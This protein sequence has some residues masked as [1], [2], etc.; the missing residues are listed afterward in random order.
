MVK[1]V[2]S[3]KIVNPVQESD[4]EIELKET[5]VIAPEV[6]QNVPVEVEKKVKRTY[7]ISD[8]ARAKKSENM[9]LVRMKKMDNTAARKQTQDDLLQK[10][11]E[12]L[13]QKVMKK[14]EAEKKK[15]EKQLYQQ[16]LKDDIEGY[17][18]DVEEEVVPKAKPKPR[19]KKEEK[20]Y[21][22]PEYYQPEPVRYQQSYTPLNYF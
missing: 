12:A 17:E 11:E 10:E 3:K 4:N 13:H 1:I 20:R 5:S 14:V 9:K 16:Y 15:R 7:N 18:S 22:E 8:E 19:A 21:T 2:N 6:I